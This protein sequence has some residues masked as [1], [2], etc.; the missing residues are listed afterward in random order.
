MKHRGAGSTAAHTK[1]TDGQP[2]AADDRRALAF[3]P[4]AP[5]WSPARNG[6][7][8]Q[9]PVVKGKSRCRMHG[10]AKGS[11]APHGERNGNFK[12]GRFTFEAIQERRTVM[13][14]VK[15]KLGDQGGKG[16]KGSNYRVRPLNFASGSLSS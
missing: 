14:L 13:A 8:C 5:M 7:R 15:A 12:H 4:G 10:G 3:A 9:S 1:E 11:G 2:H 6:M 16:G